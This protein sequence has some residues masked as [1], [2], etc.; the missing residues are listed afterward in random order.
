MDH[1][2]EVK[3]DKCPKCKCWRLP[4]LFLNAKGRKLKTCDKCRNRYKCDQCDKA[5]GSKSHLNR[6][7]KCVHLGVT[8]SCPQC[9][10]K[11]S[12]NA[13]L[14]THIKSVHSKIKDHQCPQCDYKFSHKCNLNAHIKSVHDK[15]KDHSCPQCD[16][17]FS[18]KGVLNAHIKQIH[19]KIK[20]HSCPTC[21]YKCSRKSNLD[22][23]IKLCTGELNC[24]G[25][26]KICMEI[27]QDMKVKYLYNTTDEKF[28]KQYKK[29][30]RFDFIIPEYNLYIEYDGRQHFEPVRFGGISTERA[31]NKFKKQQDHDKMKNEF[32]GDNLLRIKYDQTGN[33]PD[34][35]CK[36]IC[37][38][39]NWGFEDY[40]N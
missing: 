13:N 24:S 40:S 4:E 31:Q 11:F 5:Y 9:D 26:E 21:N 3:H 12:E 8:Y 33:I 2:Q 18:T 30:L 32:C 14:N 10:S 38:N 7:I 15:I 23:H 29:Y 28:I 20:D 19:T 1:K 36:F 17:K 39:S 27:L 35:I 25:G 22:R 34:I 37:D 16:Y 6:H